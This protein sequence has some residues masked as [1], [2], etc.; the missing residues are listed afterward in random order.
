M[1]QMCGLTGWVDPRPCGREVLE[2]MTG[3]LAHRGPDASGYFYQGSVALG[4]RRLSI[5][6]LNG[7]S[8][9][10]VHGRYVLAYNGELYN[11]KE[12]RIE[13]TALGHVF[14]TEGD[15]EALLHA[16]IEWG[17]E[18]LPRLQ[19]MFAFAFWDGE[20]LLLAR[21]HFGV[22]PLY[23]SHQ[24]GRLLF[25]SELKALLVHPAVSREIDPKAIGLYLECQYIPAPF[26]MF[27][28]IQKLPS[29]HFL[30]FKEG[31]LEKRR[32]WTPS[33]LPKSELDEPAA[34]AQLETELRRS[35]SSMLMADVPLGA[36]VSGGLDSSLIAALM[37]SECRQPIKL[38]TI[39]LEHGHSEHS[40]AARVAEYLGAEFYPLIIQPNDLLRAIGAFDEP[41]GDQAALPTLLLSEMTA[42]HVKVVLSGEG[43]DEIFAGYSNY[44]KR[45]QEAPISAKWG[46]FY[47]PF[48]RFM[49]EKLRKNR[50]VKAMSRPLSRRYTTIPN[51]FDSETHRSLLSPAL[52]GPGLEAL[53]ELHY[54]ACDSDEYLDQMLH[55]DQN[56]WLPD[57]LLTKVDRATMSH[58]LEARVPYLDHRLAEFAARLPARFKMGKYL[59]KKLAGKGLL[60]AEI[61]QR[62]KWGFVIPLKEWMAGELKPLLDDALRSLEKRRIFRPGAIF[63]RRHHATR[64]FSLLTLEWW[65]R[66]YAPD[67]YTAATPK[68]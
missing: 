20:S 8:Q 56:L 13:L 29:A 43:A 16:L 27:Q 30:R 4:H 15:T 36:F 59:L 44:A 22:K 47:A 37:Q 45:L 68:V 65:F 23:I 32:Y 57:D 5:I 1:F 52:I 7:S 34:L 58:S 31:R 50:L 9:P 2:Q 25:G 62:P 64:L 6:D 12:L 26:T 19:G 55:I 42:R 21:D 18:I 39:G 60:P 38:F 40:H 17:E 10:M 67:W 51:L 63:G 33:Y 48:H 46:R 35:V 41:F 53:A 3:V 28:Q 49:P 24:N 54:F 11:F 14:Q 61:V 66:K